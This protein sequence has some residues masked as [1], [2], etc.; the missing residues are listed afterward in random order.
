[1]KFMTSIILATIFASTTRRALAATIGCIR[2][3]DHPVVPDS[4]IVVLKSGTNMEEHINSITQISAWSPG[5][6]FL[7]SYWY[8]EAILNGYSAHATGAPLTQIL[9]CPD[10]EY[11]EADGIVSIGYDV[12]ELDE[13]NAME[14]NDV[15]VEME[16]DP[17]GLEGRS[18]LGGGIGINIFLIDT[19][20]NPDHDW[21]GG[22]VKLGG[23]FGPGYNPKDHNGHGMHVAGIAIGVGNSL[24]SSATVTL[25]K[26]V[27]DAG[28]G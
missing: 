20:V 18:P 27:S 2:M 19:G 7:I 11:V 21:F 15:L 22:C 9:N 4:Y 28:V 23:T 25:V 8:H 24:A 10:I 6:E 17:I 13:E 3:P 26:V 12:H 5:L 16:V 14:P 1:M